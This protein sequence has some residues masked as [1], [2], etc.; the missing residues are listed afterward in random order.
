MSYD[1]VY[2]AIDYNPAKSGEKYANITF[3]Y[4][5]S[6]NITNV[7]KIFYSDNTDLFCIYRGDVIKFERNAVV[8]FLEDMITDIIAN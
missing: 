7:I 2:C 6:S 8:D 1:K 4:T 3:R 5:V